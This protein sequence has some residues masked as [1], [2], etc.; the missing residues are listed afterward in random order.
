MTQPND[1]K[2]AL[3]A[4]EKITCDLQVKHG[5]IFKDH[6]KEMHLIRECLSAPVQC[7]PEEMTVEDF[8]KLL[9]NLL[10]KNINTSLSA[11]YISDKFPNG[12]RIIKE[13]AATGG[14]QK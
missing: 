9:F 3:E 12:I 13:S 8:G 2:Q 6:L 1:Y 10:A 7:M 5:S 14:A 4:L 11:E